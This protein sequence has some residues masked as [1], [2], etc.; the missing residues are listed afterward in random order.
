ME[1]LPVSTGWRA[2]LDEVAGLRADRKVVALVITAIVAVGSLLQARTA[3]VIAPPARPRDAGTS[4]T[5]SPTVIVVHVAGAVREPGLYELMPGARVADALEAAG[6]ARS[7]ADL[8]AINL[9]GP[10]IDGAQILVPRKGTAP[11]S[12]S[13]EAGAEPAAISLNVADQATLETIPGVGPVTA[14]AIIQW[15]DAQGGFSSIDQLLEVDGIGPA[16]LESIRP[17]VTL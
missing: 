6:G 7:A 3:P 4:T 10:A 9:A 17:Y 8:D 15:R 1:Q 11:S 5:P 16:T 13:P 14:Q 2:R 12:V